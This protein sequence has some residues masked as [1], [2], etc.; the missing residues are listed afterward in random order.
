M[1]QLYSDLFNDKSVP[2]VAYINTYVGNVQVNQPSYETGEPDTTQ[3]D[4]VHQH[5]DTQQ[6]E[7]HNPID[8]STNKPIEYR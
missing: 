4:P 3:T 2:T 8:D 5:D 1:V 7:C 6:V